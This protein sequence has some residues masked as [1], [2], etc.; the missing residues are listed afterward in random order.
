MSINWKVRARNKAWWLALIPAVL[1]LV[2]VC[3][4]PFGY[5]WD[6]GALNEELAAIINAV[7]AV[8]AILGVVTDPTTAGLGDSEL[9]MTYEEPRDDRCADEEGRGDEHVD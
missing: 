4:V 1:L 3:A 8:L 5:T 6:F 2:Q 9:A 7:F